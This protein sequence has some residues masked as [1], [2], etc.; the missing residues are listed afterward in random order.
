MNSSLLK[1]NP[2]V[3]SCVHAILSE[4]ILHDP[5]AVYCCWHWRTEPASYP[6]AVVLLEGFSRLL[7]TASFSWL[8]GDGP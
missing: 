5:S 6:M 4:E 3:R 2:R 7:P 1:M 8:Y